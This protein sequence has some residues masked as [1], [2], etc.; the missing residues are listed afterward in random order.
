MCDLQRQIHLGF[1]EETFHPGTHMCLVFRDEAE[2]RRIVSRF[3]GSGLVD[4]EQVGYF[5]DAADPSDVTAWLAEMDVDTSFL[6]VARTSDTYY[7]SGTFVPMEMCDRLRDTWNASQ[8]AGFPGCRVT[9][10]MTWALG[11]V[12][13]AERLMEYEAEVNSVV[14]THPVTAMCQYDANRFSGDLIFQALQ[15]HPYMVMND[16][17]VRNPYYISE[18]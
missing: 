7:P 10:E 2:R 16:Q 6:L 9:G 3:V 4:G 1:S 5:A 11:D 15:V 13:G 18:E 12:P 8:A 14:K 17:L